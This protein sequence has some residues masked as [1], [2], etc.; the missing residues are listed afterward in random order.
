MGAHQV[1]TGGLCRRSVRRADGDDHQDAPRAGGKP[2]RP[3]VALASRQRLPPG[4]KHDAPLS[5]WSRESDFMAD[6]SLAWDK[7]AGEAPTL[8]C[9]K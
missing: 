6:R 7:A 8:S 1:D 4:A 9:A 5:R 3:N 2:G